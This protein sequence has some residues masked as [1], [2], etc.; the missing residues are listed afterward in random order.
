MG[1]SG[2]SHLIKRAELI[3]ELNLSWLMEELKKEA[4]KDIEND[5]F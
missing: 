4:R 1:C 3:C 5:T 2:K